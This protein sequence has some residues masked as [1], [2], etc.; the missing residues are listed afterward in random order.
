MQMEAASSGKE[1]SDKCPVPKDAGE[2]HPGKDAA[3]A[4]QDTASTEPADALDDEAAS[5]GNQQMAASMAKG[6]TG[7]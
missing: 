1:G 7:L 2:S 3:T 4:N 5:S 6:A